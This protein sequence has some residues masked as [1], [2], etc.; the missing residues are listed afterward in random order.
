M[1]MKS[2]R[3]KPF[4]QHFLYTEHNKVW[5]HKLCSMCKLLY[6]TQNNRITM[7]VN[8]YTHLG[9]FIQPAFT[10][11]KAIWEASDT[12]VFVPQM[13]FTKQRDVSNNCMCTLLNTSEYK[14]SL[15]LKIV[16]SFHDPVSNVGNHIAIPSYTLSLWDT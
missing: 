15:K 9:S 6:C 8:I 1:V 12:P 5:C 4:S 7:D 2:L 3:C 14:Q 13:L 16:Y 11:V 10:R